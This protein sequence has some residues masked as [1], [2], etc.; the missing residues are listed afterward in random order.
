MIEHTLALVYKFWSLLKSMLEVN[1]HLLIVLLCHHLH[2]SQV[3]DDL[4]ALAHLLNQLLSVRFV[5]IETLF[6]LLNQLSCLSLIFS[7][8]LKLRL[9]HP[10]ALTKL[11]TVVH[12]VTNFPPQVSVLPLQIGSLLTLCLTCS[13]QLANGIL[14]LIVSIDQL[15][16]L[17]LC[18]RQLSFQ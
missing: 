17:L 18:L 8:F 14:A 7:L 15:A 2:L 5:L 1:L 3:A 16:C 6:E 9:Q 12:Q 10:L 11:I 4:S 13:V